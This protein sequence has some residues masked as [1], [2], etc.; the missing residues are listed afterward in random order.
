LSRYRSPGNYGYTSNYPTRE[1][2]H[3]ELIRE[4]HLLERID[5]ESDPA[6]GE[7]FRVAKD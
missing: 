4:Q 1:L 3:D 7:L 2:V 5:V 6:Y